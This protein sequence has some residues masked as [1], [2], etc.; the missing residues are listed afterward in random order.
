MV[1]NP[2]IIPE[3]ISN[4]WI[5]DHGINIFFTFD[6]F[7]LELSIKDIITKTIINITEILGIGTK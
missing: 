6:V 5:I 4:N 2:L 1:E 3:T 7:I